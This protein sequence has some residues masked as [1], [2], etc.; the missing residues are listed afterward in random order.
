[1]VQLFLQSLKNTTN[2][3]KTPPTHLSSPL[4][5]LAWTLATC[6][7][8]VCIHTLSCCHISHLYWNAAELVFLKWTLSNILRNIFKQNSGTYTYIYIYDHRVNLLCPSIPRWE[9]SHFG[10]SDAYTQFC[11][12]LFYIWRNNDIVL[13]CKTNTMQQSNN[14]LFKKGGSLSIPMSN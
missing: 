12:I 2:K 5:C 4:L 9:T 3:P 7:Y 1:M 13:C 11:S 10:F 14:F 8:Q 6:L